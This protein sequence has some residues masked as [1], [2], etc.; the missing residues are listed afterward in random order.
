MYLS[1][2]NER[3]MYMNLYKN[4]FSYINNFEKYAKRYQCH[5]CDRTFNHT[6]NLKR[7]IKSCCTD[8]EE[9]YPG[10]KFKT[11][12]TIFERLE[13][14][15][16]KVPEK[17]RYYNLYKFDKSTEDYLQFSLVPIL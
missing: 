16:I 12:D 14:V 15:G 10:G 8:I 13:K 3:P 6:G 2:L 9:V 11:N 5:N 4:H 7:H 17:D 1:R